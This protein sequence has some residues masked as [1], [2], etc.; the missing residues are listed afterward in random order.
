MLDLD[1]LGSMVVRIIPGIKWGYD[2]S[3]LRTELS[4]K[5][6]EATLLVFSC[7]LP[8]KQHVFVLFCNARSTTVF[9]DKRKRRR[10]AVL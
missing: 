1:P 2:I 9:E 5:Q 7:M 3:P 6:S 4:Q 10:L 8:R